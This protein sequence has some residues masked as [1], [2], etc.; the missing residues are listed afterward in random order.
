MITGVAHVGIAVRDLDAA[1]RTYEQVLDTRVVARDASRDQGV[2]AAFLPVGDTQLELIEPTGADSPI[3]RYLDRRGALH[4][5]C[6]AVDDVASELA[7]LRAMGAR[8][9]D[10]AP[11]RP[12]NDLPFSEYA[13]VHHGVLGGVLVELVTPRT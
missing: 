8:L 11:R 6:F 1:V 12:D 5:V 7:R 4:H 2:R 10:R 13:W 3:A 9:I